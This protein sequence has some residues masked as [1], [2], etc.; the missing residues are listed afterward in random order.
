MACLKVFLKLAVTCL[1]IFMSDFTMAGNQ[2]VIK[3]KTILMEDVSLYPFSTTEIQTV[4][5]Q[6][7]YILFN[8]GDQNKLYL[9][10]RKSGNWN[11]INKTIPWF[12][13]SGMLSK[14]QQLEVYTIV[15]EPTIDK[16]RIQT[17]ISIYEINSAK[18]DLEKPD[19]TITIPA[20]KIFVNERSK[21]GEKLLQLPNEDGHYLLIGNCDQA[22]WDPLAVIGTVISGGHAGFANWPFL[23]EI[24]DVNEITYQKWP[25]NYGTNAVAKVSQAVL[26]EDKYHFVGTWHREYMSSHERIEYSVFDLKSRKWSKPEKIYEEKGSYSSPCG[27]PAIQA[28]D[29]NIVIAWSLGN[30]DHLGSGLFARCKFNGTWSSTDKISSFSANPLLAQD[31]NDN[32]CAFWCEDRKGILM[33]S[34]LNRKWS[35]PC[36]IVNDEKIATVNVPWNIKSDNNGN[37]HVVYFQKNLNTAD[38]S[39]MD[40]IYACLEKE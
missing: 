36:I 37:I 11:S 24:K 33:S 13:P 39:D 20:D 10:Q 19:A 8:D 22:K 5:G 35:E 15:N 23:A 3:D 32:I 26:L 16:K 21:T 31:N 40:M 18:I 9:F 14:Q 17:V 1:V 4:T 7:I 27:N 30:D 6:D 38:P 28:N 12:T 34:F 2:Y 29:E 25:V